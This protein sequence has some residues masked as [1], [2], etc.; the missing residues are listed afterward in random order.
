MVTV[1]YCFVVFGLWCKGTAKKKKKKLICY[2]FCS[3]FL[4][5]RALGACGG[6]CVPAF[7]GGRSGRCVP[8]LVLVFRL[9]LHPVL[10]C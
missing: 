10:F 1:P 6:R 2:C 5:A 8:A 9:W 3:F 4:Y 7:A